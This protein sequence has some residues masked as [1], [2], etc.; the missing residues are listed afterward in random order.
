MTHLAQEVEDLLSEQKLH[1]GDA[2]RANYRNTHG[3]EMV[4]LNKYFRIELS[5]APVPTL[6]ERE[7]LIDDLEPKQWLKY[8][9]GHVLPTLVRFNLPSA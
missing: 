2:F 9:Q 3:D 8:F 4:S 7:C 1:L 6:D 5:K